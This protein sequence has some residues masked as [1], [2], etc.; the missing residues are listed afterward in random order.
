MRHSKKLQIL[1]SH[2]HLVYNLRESIIPEC[3]LSFQNR[4]GTGLRYSEKKAHEKVHRE[5]DHL[6]EKERCLRGL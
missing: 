3:V 6:Q 4:K 2:K 1:G 5:D